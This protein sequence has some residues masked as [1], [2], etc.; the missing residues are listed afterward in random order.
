MYRKFM[1]AGMGALVLG[2]MIA[3]SALPA[4][5][6]QWWHG[7]PPPPRYERHGMRAGYAWE[8]GHWGWSGGRWTWTPGYWVAVRPGH[9]WVP[10]HWIYGPNGRRWVP[11]HWR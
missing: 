2:A 11:G 10:G 8:P 5:A 7:N 6:Q 1:R 9:H 4:P 3:T